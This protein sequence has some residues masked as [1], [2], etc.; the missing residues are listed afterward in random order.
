MKKIIF[1]GLLLV[2][3][4]TSV[5]FTKEIEKMMFKLKNCNSWFFWKRLWKDFWRQ[6]RRRNIWNIKREVYVNF[7]R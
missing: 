6:I 3:F 2:V 5:S 1:I 7:R 4:L